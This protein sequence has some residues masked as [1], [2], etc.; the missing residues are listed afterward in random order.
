MYK[1][2]AKGSFTAPV[3]GPFHCGPNHDSPKQFDYE[4][5][6][7]WHNKKPDYR[8]FFADNTDFQTYMDNIGMIDVSCE[9]LAQR[10]GE[11]VH[12]KIAGGRPKEVIVRIWAIPQAAMVEYRHTAVR[13][14]GFELFAAFGFLADIAR[15][16][17]I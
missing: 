11:Y 3:S 12:A 15:I 8:G 7:D 10:V 6:V 13:L 1:Q 17:G 14:P 5:E 2:L 16:F 4:I 9:L